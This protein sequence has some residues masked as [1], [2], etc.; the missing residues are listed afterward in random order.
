MDLN[1][2]SKINNNDN[3]G[4]AGLI[5][6]ESKKLNSNWLINQS[7]KIESISKNF[8]R[9]ERF[10]E[11]EFERNWNIQQLIINEGQILSSAKINLKHIDNGLFQYGLNSFFIKNDFKGYKNDLKIK[12]N[13]KMYLNFNGSL[14]NS[15]GDLKTALRHN[16]N[17]YVPVNK[18]KI[19]FIDINENNRF[20]SND[21]LSNNSYRFTIGNSILKI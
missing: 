1:T 7:Y 15:S 2:F 6:Y 8:K 3:I 5:G 9:I 17:L 4:F 12:W 11:V 16:T 13:K 18:F 14:L 10:R 19:G 21:S 20:Y